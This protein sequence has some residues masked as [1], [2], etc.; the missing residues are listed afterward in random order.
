MMMPK[1]HIICKKAL[2]TCLN[3]F[4]NDLNKMFKEIFFGHTGFFGIFFRPSKSHCGET[5]YLHRLTTYWCITM[6]NVDPNSRLD[7]EILPLKVG[8]KRAIAEIDHFQRYATH[9]LLE[10]SNE[11]FRI[12]DLPYGYPST[13]PRLTPEMR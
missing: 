5:T 9:Q 6:P 2:R 3:M 11:T 13:M 10:I 1:Y 8:P 12:W 7:G 4:W